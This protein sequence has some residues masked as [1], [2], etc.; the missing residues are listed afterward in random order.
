MKKIIVS[1]DDSAFWLKEKVVEYM[2]ARGYEFDDASLDDSGNNLPYYEAGR[3]VGE[4][5][6]SKRYQYGL[7]FCGSGMGVNITANRFQNVY[8]ALCESV[9]TAALARKINNANVLAL[10]GNIVAPDLA[11]N[12]VDAFFNTDFL[13]GFEGETK[14][15]LDDAIVK[16]AEIDAEAHNNTS[17]PQ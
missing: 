10:G 2:A 14:E 16:L 6:S 13:A 4:A 8:C 5:V 9:H 15:F 17:L 11:C 12:M 7:V 3:R 1:S